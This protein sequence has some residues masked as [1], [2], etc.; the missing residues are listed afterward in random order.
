[1]SKDES[2]IRLLNT[3]FDLSNYD[4]VIIGTPVWAGNP[5]LPC[6]SYLKRVE[7]NGEKRIAL[8]LTGMRATQ[9]NERVIGIMETEL[10][11][12][13]YDD[14]IAR[15][16]LKFRRGKLVEGEESIPVFVD[17]L[18]QIDNS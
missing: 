14:V 7:D 17:S 1:M 10:S 13:G 18:I 3:D 11:K 16:I 8:F 5:A 4:L 2:E 6:L 15:L 9:N 12:L